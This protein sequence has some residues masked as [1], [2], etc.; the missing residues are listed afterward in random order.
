MSSVELILLSL[1]VLNQTFTPMAARM[2]RANLLQPIIVQTILNKRLDVVEG[3]ASAA[4]P[5]LLAI[6]DP[7]RFLIIPPLELLSSED[8]FLR[9]KTALQ[10]LHKECIALLNSEGCF[11]LTCPSTQD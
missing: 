8:L 10:P 1:G 5:Q 7:W 4:H 2:L 11:M 6:S 3:A 9:I